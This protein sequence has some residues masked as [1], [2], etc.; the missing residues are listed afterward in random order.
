MVEEFEHAELIT[1]C[2][3][4]ER[5]IKDSSNSEDNTSELLENPEEI[6]PRY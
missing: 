6:F 1:V 2:C 4:G 5:F 3:T